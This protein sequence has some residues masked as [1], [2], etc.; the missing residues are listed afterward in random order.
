MGNGL[1]TQNKTMKPLTI[2]VSGVG[3][4][5]RDGGGDSNHVQQCKPT[6]NCHNESTLYNKYI[7]I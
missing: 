5:G 2:A 6:Q 3:L 7:L 4:R 1:L